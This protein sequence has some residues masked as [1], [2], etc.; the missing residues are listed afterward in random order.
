MPPQD[1][2]DRSAEAFFL[3]I[4]LIL[5][6]LIVL[7]ALAVLVA[8]ADRAGVVEPGPGDGEGVTDDDEGKAG[9]NE[10]CVVDRC[11][12]SG[13]V[14][15]VGFVVDGVVYAVFAVD[16]HPDA[17]GEVDV[18]LHVID[19]AGVLAVSA[20]V[21]GE[22][23][24]DGLT[25]DVFGG[26]DDPVV[27]VVFEGGQ[28]DVVV[29][30]ELS[31]VADEV[32]E[33]GVGDDPVGFYLVVGI[34]VPVVAGA[35]GE[36]VDIF[37]EA[38]RAVIPEQCV[39]A[40]ISLVL[41]GDGIVVLV[42]GE[43]DRVGDACGNEGGS[44]LWSACDALRDVGALFDAVGGNEETAWDDDPRYLAGRKGIV[45]SGFFA[46]GCQEKG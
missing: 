44:V 3:L 35:V 23:P 42:V 41:H 5:V 28:V 10:G 16:E 26:L 14:V 34:S 2:D 45:D 39:L 1:I 43:V 31:V 21:V 22:V 8:A 15:G 9:D 25:V 13:G 36:D 38:V 46:G 32:A 12:V 20:G 4:I 37:G 6:T 29:V 11:R 24:D 27:R 18:R 30:D 7:V 19:R 17:V 40:D 33:G